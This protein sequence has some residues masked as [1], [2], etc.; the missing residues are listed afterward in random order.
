MSVP[1]TIQ[2]D[3][4]DYVRK[5]DVPAG[6][7]TEYRIVVADRGFVFVG[8]TVVEDDGSM[9]VSP[10]KC[11]RVWGTDESKPGLGWLAQ[12]GPTSKTKLDASGTVRV[13][14]HALVLTLDT[15]GAKWL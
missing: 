1:T 9:V 6:P 14:K 5:T 13:P 2:I 7:P 11:I 10:A 8:P 12:N 4:V 15:D 3:G